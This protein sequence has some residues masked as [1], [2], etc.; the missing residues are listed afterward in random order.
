MLAGLPPARQRIR[1]PAAGRQ[2]AIAVA[3]AQVPRLPLGAVERSRPG[4]EAMVRTSASGR[5]AVSKRSRETL[6][7]LVGD[8]DPKICLAG[9]EKRTDWPLTA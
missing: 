8:Q 6:L 3:S 5:S 7:A 1:L 9:Y 4:P 2:P